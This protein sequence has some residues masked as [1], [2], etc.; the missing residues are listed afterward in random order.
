M[1]TEE[2]EAFDDL[3]RRQGMWGGGFTAKRQ[4]AADKV[5]EPVQ[6]QEED[7]GV[8][9][10]KQLAS[11]KRDTQASFEGAMVRATHK[12]MAER[13]AQPAQEP[14]AWMCENAV[15]HKYFRWKKPSGSY[16]PIALYTTPPKREWVGLTDEERIKVA[17]DCGAMDAGWLVFL[18]AV[19]AKLKEKNNG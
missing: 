4:M 14:V 10:E 13:E 16:K 19:E 2:D 6:E 8:I 15:G 1:K 7:W 12:V 11:I 18:E 5:Q 9:A 17:I 3:A